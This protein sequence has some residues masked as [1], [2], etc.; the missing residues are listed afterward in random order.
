[1]S[2]VNT[3]LGPV[4]SADL[5][6]TLSHEHIT[7]GAAGT[8][9]TYPGFQDRRGHR[10]RR[11]SRPGR[12]LRRRRPHHHRR[13]YPRPG[14][15][16]TPDAGG[17]PPLRRPRHPLLRQPPGDPQDLLG[18]PGGPGGRPVHQGN[19]GGH[20]G[21]RGSRPASSRSPATGAASPK[22]RRSSFA[23]PPAPA[24]PPEPASAP[25][26]GPPTA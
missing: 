1:M 9:A 23:P 17:Q 8:A 16:H 25:T 26:P 7:L 2:Q 20:R 18:R 15:R 10:R 19:R 6:F 14:P 24:T 5:G 3:V 21:Y 11:D 4:D 13:N 22:M 12:S